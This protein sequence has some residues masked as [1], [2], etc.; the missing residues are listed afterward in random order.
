MDVHVGR[1]PVFDASG[2]VVG[3]ELLFRDGRVAH[4]RVS[5]GVVAT[6]QVILA[7]FLDL[8]LPTLVGTGMAFVNLPRPFVTGALP[9]P[10][11]SGSLVLEILEDVG[12]DDELREGVRRLR[13]A[14]HRIALDDFVWTDGTAALLPLVDLVKVDVLQH[15]DGV[16]ELIRRCHAAGVGVVAEKVETPAQLATCRALDVEYYQGYLLQRPEVLT[17]RSLSA[18]QMSCLELVRALQRPGVQVAE[19]VEIVRRD[20]GLSYRLL[21]A[22]NGASL[23]LSRRVTALRQ[24]LLLLG[25]SQLRRWALLMVVADLPDEAAGGVEA[26]FLRAAMCERLAHA[27]EADPDEAFVVGLLS[28]LDTLLGQPLPEVLAQLPVAPQTAAAVL[29]RQGP[30]GEVLAC[31][32]SYEDGNLAVPA[33]SALPASAPREAFTGALTASVRERAQL[34]V[35]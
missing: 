14:G 22:A 5:D 17:A 9:L 11:G 31:V 21:Q 27:A 18:R 15:G 32:L 29:A 25:L 10:P 6:A 4:A 34:L 8:G 16:P 13:Q 35:S 12:Y 20:P 28:S 1:Q 24:A 2:R 26:A 19:L 7:A 30:L 23:G 33:G 3:A